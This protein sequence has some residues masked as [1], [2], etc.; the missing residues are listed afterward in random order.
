MRFIIVT[1][2]AVAFTFTKAVSNHNR[3]GKLS[4]HN[5]RVHA[6][7]L[8]MHACFKDVLLVRVLSVMNTCSY[9]VYGIGPTEKLWQSLHR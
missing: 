6:H 4:M 1:Q 9:Y 8:Y 3:R 5:V 7:T 2:P